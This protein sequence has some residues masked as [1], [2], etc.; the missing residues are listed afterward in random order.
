[1]PQSFYFVFLSFRKLL[2]LFIA[3]EELRHYLAILALLLM[4][5][6]N[7]LA[8]RHE[9]VLFFFGTFIT[10]RANFALDLVFIIQSVC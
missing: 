1:M 6:S 8:I 4:E 9:T 7:K 5:K 2:H 3:D 10:R